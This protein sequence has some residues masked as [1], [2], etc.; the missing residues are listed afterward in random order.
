MTEK[1]YGFVV[2]VDKKILES[3]VDTFRLT[4]PRDP[5]LPYDQIEYVVVRINSIAKLIGKV[6]AVIF[7]REHPECHEIVFEKYRTDFSEKNHQSFSGNSHGGETRYVSY[8]WV[9]LIEDELKNA[10]SHPVDKSSTILGFDDAKIAL[11]R[12]YGV[13]TDSIKITMT[14]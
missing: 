5:R 11:A 6:E 2:E 7:N 13:K 8:Y 4:I 3:I 12:R 9:S 1:D 14:V 10:K